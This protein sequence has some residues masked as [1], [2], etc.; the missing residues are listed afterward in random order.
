MKFICPG[1][2]GCKRK[3]H[4]TCQK[5]YPNLIICFDMRGKKI[6]STWTFADMVK[7]AMRKKTKR[8]LQKC[9]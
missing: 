4:K 9:K 6:K 1:E 3:E 5:I 7:T 8:R 2:N